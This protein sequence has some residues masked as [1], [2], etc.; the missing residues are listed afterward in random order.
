MPMNPRNPIW[1]VLTLLAF[2][3]LPG[4]HS[5]MDEQQ[6]TIRVKI[7]VS[8]SGIRNQTMAETMELQAVS[9]FLDIAAIK[10]PA[11]AFVQETHVEQGEHVTKGQ[12]LFTLKTREATALAMDTAHPLAFSG[13]IRVRAGVAGIVTELDHPDG[14][15]VQEGDN[16]GIIAIPSSLVFILEVPFE[17]IGSVQVNS[18]CWLRLPDGRKISGKITARLPYV[19]P[20]SQTQQFIVT[21]GDHS[22]IPEH[23]LATV[24]IPAV[25]HPNAV[26]L[27]RSCVLADEIMQ[28]FWVMELI[29]DTI[30]VKVPVTIG[31]TDEDRVE[32]LKPSFGEGSLFLA[33]GNYGLGDTAFVQVT[34]HEA[35]E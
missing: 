20:K 4:C 11:A 27:P 16:L 26:T 28:H 8:V 29:N 6:E 30:A 34:N 10:S 3:F 35:D 15:F 25:V 19:S 33:T 12:Q 1:P 18:S 21:P 7:P 14:D 32:I 22:G 31:I 2:L 23:L 13:L 17:Q 5:P 9:K 24:M